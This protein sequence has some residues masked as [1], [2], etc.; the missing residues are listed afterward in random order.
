MVHFKYE[1]YRQNF[2]N[3]RSRKKTREKNVFLNN[4][5]KQRKTIKCVKENVM[6]LKVH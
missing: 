2:F 6:N 1:G 3:F 5:F 4:K